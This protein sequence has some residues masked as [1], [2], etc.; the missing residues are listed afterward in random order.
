MHIVSQMFKLEHKADGDDD[1]TDSLVSEEE[2]KAQTESSQLASV[3]TSQQSFRPKS[4]VKHGRAVSRDVPIV[5][6]YV[7]YSR[8]TFVANSHDKNKVYEKLK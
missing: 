3:K 4:K 5:S 8:S 1:E 6:D 2:L 7:K